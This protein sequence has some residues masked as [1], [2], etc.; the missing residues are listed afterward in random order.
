MAELAS[1]YFTVLARTRAEQ[2]GIDLT[3]ELV[4]LIAAQRNFQANA[5]KEHIIRMADRALY[6][7]KQKGRNQV[8]NYLELN[9]KPAV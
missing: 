4:G 9:L 6:L 1:N 5:K 2:L 8:R 3:I 7:A